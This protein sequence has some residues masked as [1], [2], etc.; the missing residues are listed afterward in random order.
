MPSLNASLAYMDGST[1]PGPADLPLVDSGIG[2]CART[3]AYLNI[4]HIFNLRT[5]TG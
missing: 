2:F 4:T 3:T 1:Q 5:Y